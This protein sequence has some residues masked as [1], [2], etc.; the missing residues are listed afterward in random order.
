MKQSILAILAALITSMKDESKRYLSMIVP[1]I[2]SSLQPE[3]ESRTY[4]LEDALDLW[5][6]VLVQS[7]EATQ[8]IINLTQYLFPLFNTTT[9]T[10]RKALELTESYFLLAPQIMLQ[11]NFQFLASFA[12]L[13]GTGLKRE[14]NGIITHLIDILI[15][16]AY[17]IGGSSAIG[18]L[19]KVLVETQLIS[20]IILGLKTAHDTH[21]TT[22]PNRVY[23]EVDG[24][25]ETD[26]FSVFA[27]IALANPS[28]FVDLITIIASARD[29]LFEETINWLLTEW[30]SQLDNIGAPPSKKLM[31]LA[32]TALLALGPQKWLLGRL[33]E[34][35]T[36]WTDLVTEI[37]EYPEDGGAGRDSMVYWD[38]EGLK[39][40]RPESPEDERRR[41]VGK[42]S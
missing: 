4:L 30:F 5:S 36:L 9:D 19:A 1:L 2:A 10:L 23:S 33:Q 27:R 32:L 18:T 38:P 37:V 26:Y 41:N 15:Q 24:V 31:C 39:P 17:N 34:F 25:V 28:T 13:L 29:E 42:H 3:S 16:V 7:P 14:A 40:E 12:K 11:D 6:V 22:G 21:Q 8:D 20:H 35:M